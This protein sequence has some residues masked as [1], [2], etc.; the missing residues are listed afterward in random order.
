[1][2]L[3][4]KPNIAKP[5]VWHAIPGFVALNISFLIRADDCFR[6]VW[7]RHARTVPMVYILSAHLS[8]PLN[9]APLT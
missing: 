7:P 1:M 6:L 3:D 2:N 4:M 8:R 5:E 9:N